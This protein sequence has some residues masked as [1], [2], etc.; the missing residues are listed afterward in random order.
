[1]AKAKGAKR[2]A[3]ARK[4]RKAVVERKKKT[5]HDGALKIVLRVLDVPRGD[6]S[7]ME[8]VAREIVRRADAAAALVHDLDRDAVLLAEV[9]RAPVYDCGGAG[10]L[11]E[12]VAGV[13]EK[14]E[15]PEACI[16]REL[17]E[18]GGVRAPTL[19]PIAAVFASPGY[20]TERIHLFYAPIRSADL[21]D[22]DARGVDHGE[23][24]ARVWVSVSAFL[25]ALPACAD[26][27]TL[28]A[29]Q[30]LAARVGNDA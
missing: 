13:V 17:M 2:A 8:A 6:G 9:F 22:P 10:W 18:A 21:V 24:V 15:A 26:A 5:V 29:G 20:S 7:M 11:R 4:S 27:K 30:W 25:D 28:I 16:R 19:E 12:I 1:M 14:G 3:G 23:D